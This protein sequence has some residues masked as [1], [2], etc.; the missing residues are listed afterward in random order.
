MEAFIASLI[1]AALGPVRSGIDA[2]SQRLSAI[3]HGFTD[4]LG[5][6]RDGFVYWVGRGAHWAT[7]QARHGLVVATALRWLV[8]VAIP[9]WIE[10][11][12]AQLVAWSL[13]ELG[14]LRNLAAGW[15]NAALGWVA[16]RIAEGV[17]ELARLRDWARAELAELAADARA[18]RD[19]VFGVLGSPERLVSWILA[20]L[21]T[22]LLRYA[23]DNAER[24]AE[25]AWT[26]RDLIT[27]RTIDVAEQWID[28]VF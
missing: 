1:A 24:L 6:A 16:D 26:R 9:R 12:A 10:A 7:Q 23:L 13:G 25:L 21:L 27:N 4:A 5:R 28:G 15:V 19:R 11:R 8:L 3:Y 22:A 17:A 14:S 18:V 2:V 20:A